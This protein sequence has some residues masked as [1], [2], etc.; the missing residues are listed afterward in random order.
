M[1]EAIGTGN[2]KLAKEVRKEQGLVK[3]TF[4][5]DHGN[6]EKGDT[7]TMHKSTAKALEAHKIGKSGSKVSVKLV[8]ED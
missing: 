4:D 1:A 3:F 5:K 2:G 8:K 7:V 6:N